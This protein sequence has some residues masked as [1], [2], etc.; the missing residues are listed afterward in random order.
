MITLKEK[1][2]QIQ[3]HKKNINEPKFLFIF[4]IFY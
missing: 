3:D 1:K 2:N 4:I